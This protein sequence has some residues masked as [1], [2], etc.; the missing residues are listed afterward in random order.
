MWKGDA[1]HS[2][3][4]GFCPNL[5]C[6][7]GLTGGTPPP[8]VALC[9]RAARNGVPFD[10]QQEAFIK[11]RCFPRSPLPEQIRPPPSHDDKRAQRGRAK[12][13]PSFGVV[14][15][16]QAPTSSGIPGPPPGA[17]TGKERQPP[18]A[19]PRSL[20]L[21]PPPAAKR[22]LSPR[23][24]GPPAKAPRTE[25]Q[26]LDSHPST[27]SK[28]PASDPFA[29]RA[30]SGPQQQSP[31]TAQSAPEAVAAPASLDA[32]GAHA[33]AAAFA[34][35]GGAAPAHGQPVVTELS[36]QLHRVV[37]NQGANP[38]LPTTMMALLSTLAPSRAPPAG[39]LSSVAPAANPPALR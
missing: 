5:A 6:P 38:E 27:Q 37:Q 22:M 16:P 3:C 39:E 1:T 28:A 7:L 12:A 2:L 15:Q 19:P 36:H 17:P 11:L 14:F 8:E 18:R 24:G 34:A 9:E 35:T 20:P 31:L 26:R 4:D 33:P 30:E 29:P 32:P 10:R 21:G 23:P 25:G 13:T